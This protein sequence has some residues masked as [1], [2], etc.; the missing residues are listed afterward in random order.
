MR[1]KLSIVLSLSIMLFNSSGASVLALSAPSAP[2]APTLSDTPTMTVNSPTPPP[3]PS[4]PSSPSEPTPPPAPTL[5]PTPKP[6][7]TP[8]PT[9]VPTATPA[10]VTT[11]S[12]ESTAPSSTTESTPSTAASNSTT[13]TGTQSQ[14][15]QTG[16]D[17]TINTGDANN[18]AGITTTGNNN[19]S[20]T[21][22][23]DTGGVSV[24]NSGNGTDSTNTGS[25]NIVDNDT[26]NQTNSGVVTSTLVQDSTTGNNSASRNTGGDNSITTG[27]ANTTGTLITSIN[28]N[29]AGVMVSEFNIADDHVGDYVLDFEANCISGC[30]GNTSVLNDGN[31]ADSVN[32][33]DLNLISNDAT[34]QGNDAVIDN[35]MILDA[36]SGNN[37]AS[38]NTGGNSDITTGD[39]NVAANALT[40]ANNNIAGNVIYG[41]VNIFGDL[42]GNIILPE[43][44]A[45]VTCCAQDLSVANT[46]NG[47]NSTNVINYD[48]TLADNY[49]QFNQ[50]TLDNMLYLDA[51]TGDNQTSR[52]T[53]GSNSVTTG[54]ARVDAQVLNVANNNLVGGDWWLVIVN[55]AG[56][57]VGKIFGATEGSWFGG[58]EGLAMDASPEGELSVANNGNGSGS[59]NV[60]NVNNQQTNTTT[61]INDAQINNNIRLTAN[62]G[63]NDAS[64]NTG[65]SSNITT[66]D[67]N[68]IANIVNFANNNIASGG[69]LFVTVVNV[70]GSWLGDFVSPGNQPVATNNGSNNNNSGNHSEEVARGGVEVTNSPENKTALTTPNSAPAKTAGNMAN[71]INVNA[72]TPFVRPVSVLGDTQ[73]NDEPQVVTAVNAFS[74]NP[75]SLDENK[76]ISINLAWALPIGLASI[77]GILITK[78]LRHA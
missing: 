57:W 13:G 47:D 24:I 22:G 32:V 3:A 45:G 33:V 20:A 21:A 28:T 34:F 4:G 29:T 65:G 11:S 12:N 77:V 6:S 70:F 19:T 16:T 2:S 35:N 64:R 74:G 44:A 26:T 15:S 71:N 63:E 9:V 78:K 36:N 7:S 43:G 53:N 48:A 68:I 62:T 25:V 17:N 39:A 69:R 67:A 18:S 54:D 1:S 27:D 23:G 60:V 37:T 42:I 66:G 40:F 10:P 30:G 75:S 59:T 50:L 14:D 41:V 38:R 5:A 58:S 55:E 31:G 46:G 52:N 51:N 8:K 72:N 49:I 61:Q 56:N 76:T 73:M